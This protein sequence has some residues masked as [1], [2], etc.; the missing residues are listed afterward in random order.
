MHFSHLALPPKEPDSEDTVFDF[1]VGSDGEYKL[2]T[3]CLNR[4]YTLVN[5][6]AGEWD[7]WRNHVQPFQYPETAMIDFASMLV[8]NV[9]SVRTEF[10]LNTIAKQG[11]VIVFFSS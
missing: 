10:L 4:N 8:P 3:V 7:H 6:I 11:K 5:C 1:V 9:D 2:F